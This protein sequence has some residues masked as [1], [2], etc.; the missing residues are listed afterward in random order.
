MYILNYFLASQPLQNSATS[1][2]KARLLRSLVFNV[3][4]FGFLVKIFSV[5]Q[6]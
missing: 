1:A 6:D 4:E 5:F 3:N 2:P